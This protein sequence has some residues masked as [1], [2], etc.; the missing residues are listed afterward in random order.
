MTFVF[1]TLT[2]KDHVLVVLFWIACL[3]ML[4]QT[5]DL[6]DFYQRIERG[7]VMV[8]AHR[9]DWRNFPENS[10]GSIASCI[11][12]GVDVVEVDVQRTADGHFVLMHDETINRTTNGKGRVD[13]LTLKQIRMFRLKDRSG[14]LTDFS[15][16]TLEEVAQLTADRI[17]VN[18]DK[19][20]AYFD[21]LMQ[22]IDSMDAC[23]QFI[24]KANRSS[25]YF[26]DQLTYTQHFPCLMPILNVKQEK[27]LDEFLA[28]AQPRIVELIASSDT[29][30]FTSPEGLEI[31]REHQC[32]I[33]Y[34][35]LFPA[36]SMGWDEPK[37][38]E[39]AWDWFL[40]HDAA[41]I[42][43]DYP[44]ELMA[45]MKKRGKR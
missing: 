17:V 45:F 5:R 42:Q 8:A 44:K 28:L 32:G 23:Y 3:K 37:Q 34:N 15:V 16:P 9:G 36:V 22:K 30:D 11:E 12:M 38:K 6:V 27:V 25:E 1:M 10:I 40:L 39:Q 19:S 43:T 21:V 7:E 35:S 33:W 20:A 41:V 4:G 31:L 13:A 26:Q 29:T 24:L 14:K 18:L 2:K